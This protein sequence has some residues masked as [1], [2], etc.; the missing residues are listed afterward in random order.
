M[1]R[2][3]RRTDGLTILRASRG[4]KNSSRNMMTEEAG[5]RVVAWTQLQDEHL[6]LPD[7]NE[8]VICDG[9]ERR[10]QV[11]YRITRCRRQRMLSPWAQM[12]MM[13]MMIKLPFQYRLTSVRWR[14]HSSPS[15]TEATWDG[16]NLLTTVTRLRA[17]SLLPW[18]LTSP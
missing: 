8:E 3:D 6:T 15:V 2:T 12:M 5:G 10:K 7:I 13:I 17:C 16:E 18:Q 14:N 4:K 9:N 1:L 11:P